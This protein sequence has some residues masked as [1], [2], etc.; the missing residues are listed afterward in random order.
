MVGLMEGQLG[1]KERSGGGAR[2]EHTGIHQ[3]PEILSDSDS[4]G[5]EEPATISIENDKNGSEAK[6]EEST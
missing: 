6:H 4:T 5:T 1:R 3:N 2:Q